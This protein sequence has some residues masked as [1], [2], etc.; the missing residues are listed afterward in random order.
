MHVCFW[1]HFPQ[2]C[3]FLRSTKD[4]PCG[5]PGVKVRYPNEVSPRDFLSAAR[6]ENC[7]VRGFLARMCKLCAWQVVRMYWVQSRH[8]RQE[9]EQ[10]LRSLCRPEWSVGHSVN[11]FNYAQDHTLDVKLCTNRTIKVV[12]ELCTSWPHFYTNPVQQRLK[13]EMQRH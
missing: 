10:F 3:N 1:F 5:M 9:C 12:E 8:Y 2:P 4:V 6:C 13:D 11:S 7:A